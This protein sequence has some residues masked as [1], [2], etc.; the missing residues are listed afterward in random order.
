[1]D[2]RNILPNILDVYKKHGVVL[3]NVNIFGLRDPE[4]M[5]DDIWND[6]IGVFSG[7]HCQVFR[8]TTDP[9]RFYTRNPLNENGCAHLTL[10]YHDNI[11]MIGDHKGHEALVQ[12]GNTVTVWRD[13]NRDFVRDAGEVVETGWFGINLHASFDNDDYIERASAGC[14]VVKDHRDFE[15]LMEFAKRYKKG[16]RRFS[17]LLVDRS[18]LNTVV[19]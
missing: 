3:Q 4:R 12:W 5:N 17:Y 14:Q 19:L 9:G 2:A 1:M 18:E 15:K 8:G 13:G 10:G 6:W 7:E 11:W 16:Q